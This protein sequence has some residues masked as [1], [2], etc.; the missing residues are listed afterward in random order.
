LTTGWV[1][2]TAS[3]YPTSVPEGELPIDI[4][5]F[6]VLLDESVKPVGLGA[7]AE[8]LVSDIRC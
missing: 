4:E 8:Y 5:R 3:S 6:P 7:M 2:S 1:F